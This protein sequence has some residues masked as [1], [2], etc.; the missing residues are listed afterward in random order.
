MTAS[1]FE[2]SLASVLADEGGN[3]NDPRDPGGRTSRGIT[4]REYNAYRARKGKPAGDVWKATNDEVKEI[5]HDSYWDPWCDKFPAGVDYLYFDMAVN[6][7]PSQAAKLL[8][9]GLGIHED[10]Q[11][12][13]ATLAAAVNSDTAR[14]IV[15]VSAK[16]E[17]F[18]RSLKTFK[19]FGHGWLNRA[20]RVKSIAL[21]M[22]GESKPLAAQYF[23]SIQEASMNPLNVFALAMSISKYLGE[24]MAA[25]PNVVAFVEHAIRAFND[26][27]AGK[28]TPDEFNVL[29]EDVKKIAHDLFGNGAVTAQSIVGVVPGATKTE[30]VTV[31]STQPANA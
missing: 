25:G 14:L 12:G 30:S 9:R 21:K 6:S 28:L 26:Y 5:Y 24:L 20:A 23:A 31:S 2:R 15:D 22:A 11:I 4:Q 13:P 29:F 19:T 16:R 17:A 27:R 8:Q 18:Y 1:N 10:G 3:D 7:G